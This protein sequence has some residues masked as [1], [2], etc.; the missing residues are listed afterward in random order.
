[1]GYDTKYD[2]TSGT[3]IPD[4]VLGSDNNYEQITGSQSKV[5]RA[6]MMHAKRIDGEWVG[7]RGWDELARESDT[8]ENRQRF[9]Y[10]IEQ[11]ILPLVKS[12]DIRDVS[13]THGDGTGGAAAFAIDFYDVRYGD[14]SRIGFIGPW[15]KK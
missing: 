14:T 3:G 9:A 7:N 4:N 6:V 8:P 13:V 12:G 2:A 1:M 11:A 10:F 15:G 5:A